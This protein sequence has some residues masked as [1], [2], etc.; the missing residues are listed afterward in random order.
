MNFH[1]FIIPILAKWSFHI[2][3][4]SLALRMGF[5]SVMAANCVSALSLLCISKNF[6]SNAFPSGV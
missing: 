5:F 4:A 2:E 1:L 6:L 3:L